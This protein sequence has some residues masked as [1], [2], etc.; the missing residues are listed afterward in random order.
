MRHNGEG[1]IEIDCA[2]PHDAQIYATAGSFRTNIEDDC[3]E[4]FLRID[5]DTVAALPL[6]TEWTYLQG[7]TS[8]RCILWHPTGELVGSAID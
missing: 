4:E 7:S 5:P 6:D 3:F 8:Y 2:Q 1:A